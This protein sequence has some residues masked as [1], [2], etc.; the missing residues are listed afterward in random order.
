MKESKLGDF[1]TSKPLDQWGV[2][3]LRKS[4]TTA[5][6]D[7]CDSVT[8]GSLNQ[9]HKCNRST[10]TEGGSPLFKGAIMQRVTKL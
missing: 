6:G 8:D 5:K 1:E 2:S 10:H 9:S 7:G 4:R 3:S